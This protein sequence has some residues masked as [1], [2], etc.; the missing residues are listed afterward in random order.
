MAK[1]VTI[2]ST[3][4]CVYCNIAKNYFKENNVAYEDYNVAADLGKR[5]EMVDLS[6]QMGVPVIVIGDE[7]IVGFNKPQVAELLGL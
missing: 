6:G 7:H 2:Y 1:K 3:P 5:K 4:S